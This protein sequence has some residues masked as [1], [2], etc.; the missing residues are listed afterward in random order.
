MRKGAP[1]IVL[2]AVVA[3]VAAPAFAADKPQTVCP[4]KGDNI[5]KAK[6][7]HVDMQGQRI[8]FCCRRCASKFKADPEKVFAKLAADG[9]TPENVQTAD[10]VCGMKIDPAKS[11]AVSDYKGRRVHFCGDGC[12]QEFDKDPAKFL[13]K[14]EEQSAEKK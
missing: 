4:V 2:L 10:P 14:L 6:S 11:E 7:P 13:P 5:D 9:I 3:L 1:L 12:K 8:Y